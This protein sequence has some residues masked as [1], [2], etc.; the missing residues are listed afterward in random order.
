[1][2]L[3]SL[4]PN[5]L[6]HFACYSPGCRSRIKKANSPPRKYQFLKVTSL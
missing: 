2:K 3:F 6:I 1:M 4:L 5:S